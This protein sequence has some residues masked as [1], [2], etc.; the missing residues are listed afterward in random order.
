MTGQAGRPGFLWYIEKPITAA[1]A[2]RAVCSGI[3]NTRSH[4]NTHDAR[5][6]SSR[7][8]VPDKRDG[9]V[10]AQPSHH[11]TRM[12]SGDIIR[13]IIHHNLS[14]HS[15]ERG[16]DLSSLA[17]SLH[18]L[19]LVLRTSWFR[20]GRPVVSGIQVMHILDDLHR[21]DLGNLEP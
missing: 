15:P 3:I 21:T 1:M 4:T 12:L 19:N 8:S 10:R 5:P 9:W 11:V 16:G 20:Q 7:G 2:L 17:K 6:I 18:T 14:T 13:A